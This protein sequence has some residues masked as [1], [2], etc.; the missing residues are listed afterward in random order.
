MRPTFGELFAGIGGLGLGFER[1]GMRCAWQVEINPFCR[2]VLAARFPKAKRYQDVTA[3]TWNE[4]ERVDGI[5]GGFPCQDVS[6]I[7]DRHGIDG[8][9]SGLWHYFANAIRVLRPKFIVVENVPGLL[10]RGFGRVLGDLS[11]LGYDAEWATLSAAGFGSPMLRKRLFVVAYPS[12]IGRRAN[13]AI[14]QG[15]PSHDVREGLDCW[16]PASRVA[17]SNAS[18]LFRVPQFEFLDLD[19]GISSELDSVAALGNAVV[20]QAAEFVAKLILSSR[21]IEG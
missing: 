12:G 1:A 14:F 15:Y 3:I 21:I 16:T 4:L 18:R 8:E 7:G 17:R 13:S 20:P 10:N 2:D 11:T 19:N 6:Q 9:Q 5:L